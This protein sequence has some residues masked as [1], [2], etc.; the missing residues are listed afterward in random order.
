MRILAG[1]RPAL[2]VLP[3]LITLVGWLFRTST[4]SLPPAREM[5]RYLKLM[6]KRKTAHIICFHTICPLFSEFNRVFQGH[7]PKNLRLAPKFSNPAKV[8]IRA[9]L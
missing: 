9:I 1:W 5:A 7:F 6:A 4:A 3:V 8:K 2:P